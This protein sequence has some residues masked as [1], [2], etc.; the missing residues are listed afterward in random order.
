M[1]SNNIEKIFI[2]EEHLTPDQV[3]FQKKT[4]A[5]K[6]LEKEYEYLS[7]SIK[8]A[9]NEFRNLIEPLETKHLNLAKQRVEVLEDIYLNRTLPKKTKKDLLEVIESE[10]LGLLSVVED[11]KLR[12]IYE[13]CSKRSY[14][15]YLDHKEDYKKKI[16]DVLDHM[17]EK[18]RSNWEEP[19][20]KKT[21]KQLEREAKA[22][23]KEEAKKRSIKDIYKDLIKYFHP[24]KELD[25]EKKLEKEEISKQ[26][27]SAYHKK[28]LLS[29]MELE[30]NLLEFNKNRVKELAGEKLKLYN[31]ILT[32]QKMKIESEL[33]RLKSDNELIYRG[34]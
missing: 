21:K 8:E 6:K 13:N 3:A 31:E 23:A 25:H 30:L 29:L 2:E 4:A 33:Y 26:I 1:N 20:V 24:D 32:E 19:P 11:V 22:K 28:N 18:N 16:D 14:K 7:I 15:E 5:I 34:M 9:G 17:F 10:C 12:E 27:T